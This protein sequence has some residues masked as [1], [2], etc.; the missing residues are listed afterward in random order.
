MFKHI[1]CLLYIVMSIC[2]S[3]YTVAARCLTVLIDWAVHESVSNP[4]QR[5]TISVRPSWFLF[6][7]PP[8]EL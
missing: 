4:I 7:S 1:F 6:V 5:C 3:T 8:S 2:P